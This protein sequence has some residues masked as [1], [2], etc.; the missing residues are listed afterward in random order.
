MVQHVTVSYVVGGDLAGE[1]AAGAPR[2]G[3]GERD[4][5]WSQDHPEA[6]EP[7]SRAGGRGGVGAASFP[8]GGEDDAEAGAA[9]A[10]AGDAD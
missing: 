2:R 3:G 4:E 8:G 9:P 10:R 7:R 1:R 6:G 5:G